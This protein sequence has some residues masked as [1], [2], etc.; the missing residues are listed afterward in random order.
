M[1]KS[2]HISKLELEKRIQIVKH[3]M[4]EIRENPE[5]MKK[6]EKLAS[7]WIS[8]FQIWIRIECWGSIIKS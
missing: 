8:F 6:I 4:L 3:A 7:C 5:Y 2:K 1:S